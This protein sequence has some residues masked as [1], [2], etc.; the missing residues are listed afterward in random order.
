ME[1]VAHNFEVL[2][3]ELKEGHV[4][5]FEL[6]LDDLAGEESLERFKQLELSNDSVTVIEGLG[7]DRGQSALQL[8]DVLAEL[9]ELV[10]KSGDLNVHD[11]E[12]DGHELFN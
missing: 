2:L 10:V 6:V 5:L 3:E 8:F 4:L 11:V 12:L 1:D 9:E 7:Q